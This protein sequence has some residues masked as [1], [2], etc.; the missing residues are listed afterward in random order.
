MLIYSS[1]INIF[2]IHCVQFNILF[3]LDMF[4]PSRVLDISTTI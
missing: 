2:S 4:V 1:N 3:E